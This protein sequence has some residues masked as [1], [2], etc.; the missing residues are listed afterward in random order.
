MMCIQVR[1]TD[2]FSVTVANAA[3]SLNDNDGCS[4]DNTLFNES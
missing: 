3:Y 4:V 2:G 1:V